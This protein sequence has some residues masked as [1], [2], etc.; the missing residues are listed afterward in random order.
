[1]ASLAS[2][3]TSTRL[4]LFHPNLIPLKRSTTTFRPITNSHKNNN[5]SIHTVTVNAAPQKPHSHP[6]VS[7]T[8]DTTVLLSGSTRTLTTLFGITALFIKSFIKLLPPPNLCYSIGTSSSS[9]FFAYFLRKNT[10]SSLNTPLTVV[11][12]GLKK[13]LDIYSGVLLVRVLL[14][15]FPNIPW[16]RQPLSAIRDLCDPYL[17]LFR[18]VIPPVF[19]TLDI[20]PLLAFAV[21]GTLASI[22]TVP[23]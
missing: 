20:S 16:E 13:W 15:W 18:N 2:T 6:S 8:E 4:L 17:S 5:L 1:M 23:A 12:A 19:D 9:L 10:Q 3:S 7:P 11:A 21:L 22:L 14:S